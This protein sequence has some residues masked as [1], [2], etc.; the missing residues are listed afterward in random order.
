MLRKDRSK[1]KLFK[2][3]IYDDLISPF[4]LFYDSNGTLKSK[5]GSSSQSLSVNNLSSMTSYIDSA[6]DEEVWTPAFINATALTTMPYLDGVVNRK[7]I[8]GINE[9]FVLG[10][11]SFKNI[12]IQNNVKVGIDWFLNDVLNRD[13]T[14][15]SG[16]LF[17]YKKRGSRTNPMPIANIASGEWIYS[18]SDFVFKNTYN[19]EITI[20][21]GQI[22]IKLNHKELQVLPINKTTNTNNQIFRPI[23]INNNPLGSQNNTYEPS[24]LNLDNCIDV[25]T[26]WNTYD[27]FNY[28]NVNGA[29]YSIHISEGDYFSYT[30]ASGILDYFLSFNLMPT[31]RTIYNNLLNIVGLTSLSANQAKRLKQLAFVLATGP[32]NDKVTLNI[33]GFNTTS[34]ISSITSFLSGTDASATNLSIKT[35]CQNVYKEI[36]DLEQNRVYNTSIIPYKTDISELNNNYCK[37][38]NDI[39]HQLVSKYGL[40]LRFAGDDAKITVNKLLKWKETNDTSSSYAGGPN[41]SIDSRYIYWT[42]SRDITNEANSAATPN[43]VGHPFYDQHVQAGPMRIE[44][45]L[46]QQKIY[47]KTLDAGSEEA[48]VMA[49]VI[50][51]T[52]NGR[53]VAREDNINYLLLP[54]IKYSMFYKQGGFKILNSTCYIDEPIG[55]ASLY[56]GKLDNKPIFLDISKLSSRWNSGN[57]KE[58]NFSDTDSD[59]YKKVSLKFKLYNSND[60]IKL[61]GLYIDFLRYKEETLCSC[62]SFYRE[63]INRSQNHTK[64]IVTNSFLGIE[65]TEETLKKIAFS[66]AG[67]CGT[68]YIGRDNKSFVPGIST[69]F[70]PP[71]ISYGGYDPSIISE[72]GIRIPGHPTPGEKL[73]VLD[74]RNPVY[75]D[76]VKCYERTGYVED[77][78]YFSHTGDN[79]S[80]EHMIG[81]T[82][83]G[84]GF[85]HPHYGWIPVGHRW[86][87][88]FRNKTAVVS[89]KPNKKS[90][91][92]FRGIG[93]LFD[94]PNTNRYSSTVSINKAAGIT[95]AEEISIQTGVRHVGSY[96]SKFSSEYYCD[97]CIPYRGRRNSNGSFTDTQEQIRDNSCDNNYQP[98]V[99]YR[100]YPLKDR[101]SSTQ[102]V[103]SED[104]DY[105]RIKDIEI[106]LNFVN[107][108]NIQDIKLTLKYVAGSPPS[109]TIPS[110]YY[111]LVSGAPFNNE[112]DI[113]N[114]VTSLTNQNP[115]D[116]I[117]LLNKEHIK[118]YGNEFTLR[119]SD[120][121][122]PFTYQNPLNKTENGEINY[123]S[124]L[125]AGVADGGVLHPSFKPD[126]YTDKQAQYYRELLNTY[127][128]CIIN[129]KFRKWYGSPL[130]GSKFVLEVEL[131]N[132][133]NKTNYGNIPDLHL[134]NN[135]TEELLKSNIARNSICNWEIILD[136]YRADDPTYRKQ[137][138]L[139]INHPTAE[140]ID[141]SRTS[142]VISTTASEYADGYNFLGDFKDRKFLVPPVNINAPHQYLTDFN[143]CVYPESLYNNWGFS[144]QESVSLRY[145][146]QA[147]TLFN[148]GIGA[149]IGFAASG[150]LTGGFVGMSLFGAASDL[151]VRSIVSYYASIRRAA[152]VD[153]YDKTFYDAS[154]DEYGYGLPDQALVEISVDK[155]ATWY[156]FDAKIFKYNQYSSPVY[157]PLNV[158]YQGAG[159]TSLTTCSKL[160]TSIVPSSPSSISPIAV[161]PDSFSMPES[162]IFTGQYIKA[163]ELYIRKNIKLLDG[164]PNILNHS[165]VFIGQNTYVSDSTVCIE[166]PFVKP[167]YYLKSSPF[168]ISIPVDIIYYD[169][170]GAGYK[171]IHTQ[172]LNNIQILNKDN[173]Y[174]TYLLFN[175]KTLKEKLEKN[176]HSKLIVQKSGGAEDLLS[177]NLMGTGGYLTL[178][179]IKALSRNV[180][181]PDYVMPVYGEGAWGRGSASIELWPAKQ[182]VFAE[183]YNL[184]DFAI[185]YSHNRYLGRIKLANNAI[186]STNQLNIGLFDNINGWPLYKNIE[187]YNLHKILSD[188]IQ[189]P[190]KNINALNSIFSLYTTSVVNDF[191]NKELP[192]KGSLK[193]L[194]HLVQVDIG[195]EREGMIEAGCVV[196]AI[197]SNQQIEGAI[198]FGGHECNRAR[199]S[200]SINGVFLFIADLNNSGQG[201]PPNPPLP[202]G[203]GLDPLDRYSSHIITEEE[204]SAIIRANPDSLNIVYSAADDNPIHGNITWIRVVSPSGEEIASTCAADSGLSN[205][206]EQ[207]SDDKY[208]ISIDKYQYGSY[209]RTTSIKV[210]NKIEYMCS[211]PSTQPR[212]LNCR[213]VCGMSSTYALSNGISSEGLEWTPSITDPAEV[214]NVK[215]KAD[216]FHLIAA[217]PG[218][219]PTAIYT[220]VQA[221]KHKAAIS[222]KYPNVTWREIVFNR[223]DVRM[224]CGESQR[225]TVMYIREYYWIASNTNVPTGASN[226]S[227]RAADILDATD[228]IL[229]RF[230]YNTRKLRHVDNF[231]QK[232]TIQP[233]GGVTY[234]GRFGTDE[235]PIKNSFYSWF[236]NYVNRGTNTLGT[237]IPPYY[238]MLNEMIFRGFFGSADGLEIKS[239]TSKTQYPHEWIPYEYDNSIKCASIDNQLEDV[240]PIAPSSRPDSIG[241]RLRCWLLSKLASNPYDKKRIVSKCL[242][243]MQQNGGPGIVPD[244]KTFDILYKNNDPLLTRIKDLFLGQ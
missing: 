197:Y 77:A 165:N 216:A 99:D 210:L 75:T 170:S 203:L 205:K 14:P 117:I 139:N 65:V 89:Y 158:T 195:K 26:S 110:S 80:S 201:S 217:G 60:V 180:F 242:S 31:Y 125:N 78:T 113:N 22:C 220:N 228:D 209:S 156:T 42:Q 218:G 45:D 23:Y 134:K 133:Y 87:S 123:S 11:P 190:Y 221:D 199:L 171:N 79:T 141:Y 159:D 69:R 114:Y 236:C 161:D 237:M 121:A 55:E 151:A 33:N 184:L 239:N 157:K 15:D 111:G 215:I 227:V 149:A 193:L 7:P 131:V 187:K 70:S 179:S 143:S 213:N 186:T 147:I 118:Q 35:I 88:N 177:V 64:A 138:R 25:P 240:A 235:M 142:D 90:R 135:R 112:S 29:Y 50:K 146:Y 127:N 115:S 119:F 91:F 189:Y 132:Q 126:G 233:N 81:T 152:L 96:Q 58:Y 208:W 16:I 102:I 46:G 191:K 97:E 82:V 71:V 103:S 224:S 106:K 107:F 62:D 175:D 8:L 4:Y 116:T 140:H 67:Y 172:T 150:G 53:W 20:P 198:C 200:V 222:A 144:R 192:S 128:V 52:Q 188:N 219:R 12:S 173:Q 196:E 223:P 83:F 36:K 85:F 225:D 104:L 185:G 18:A 74:M 232:Y 182:I 54:E 19:K 176:I 162:F 234:D 43:N 229:V 241:H 72:L 86:Y 122:S 206:P 2:T 57:N 47:F 6:V 40:Y 207:Y 34:Y 167:F 145:V 181:V 214:M 137:Q 61:D 68:M 39:F 101:I 160:S 48:R 30:S 148:A 169:M 211:E 168:G 163:K 243:Y 9:M 49:E 204:A 212:L 5:F 100:I 10:N 154:Y 230:K 73:P 164:K 59:E 32:Q 244:K 124:L 28:L 120:Y 108:D 129:N 174:N 153:S 136:T 66:R 105:I 130:I 41:V 178:A 63:L 21:A 183:D 166:L 44:T 76:E 56:N 3:Q 93:F 13:I 94:A 226:L 37:V 92:V 238:M 202:N 1:C 17:W 95:T 194:D 155:G 27:D 98:K 24:K 231:L 109:D 38:P 51:P 84:K